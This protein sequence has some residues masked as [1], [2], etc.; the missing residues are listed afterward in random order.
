MTT[1]K[2]IYLLITIVLYCW[3]A[4]KMA[5]LFRLLLYCMWGSEAPVFKFRS[6]G[7]ALLQSLVSRWLRNRKSD[8]LKS[9]SLKN[10]FIVFDV[11]YLLT[12]RKLFWLILLV[13]FGRMGSFPLL[14]FSLH[15]KFHCMDLG[16]TY[17]LLQTNCLTQKRE[18]GGG[19][20]RRSGRE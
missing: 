9:H 6:L 16:E 19:E 12:T 2:A 1:E 13:N 11:G 3:R 10:C 15:S 18:G 4:I 20:H 8:L 17:F 5:L 14:F 7:H